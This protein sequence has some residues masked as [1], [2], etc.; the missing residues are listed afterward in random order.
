MTISARLEALE[1]KHEELEIEISGARAAPS[2]DD[3]HIVDLKRK[4]LHLKDEIEKIR[5]QSS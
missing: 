1:K 5:V 2:T 4:K 3:L